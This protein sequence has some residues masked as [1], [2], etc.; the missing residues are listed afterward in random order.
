M[1]EGNRKRG[2][3]SEDAESSKR[4]L[5]E[6]ER[7][8]A[9]KIF[10]KSKVK[11]DLRRQ[12]RAVKLQ[13]ERVDALHR[14]Y[15]QVAN[16]LWFRGDYQEAVEDGQ[17][18][19]LKDEESVASFG[20]EQRAVE[21]QDAAL[22]FLYDD[23]F[24]IG[25]NE[26]ALDDMEDIMHDL[27]EIETRLDNGVYQD[28]Y[29]NDYTVGYNTWREDEDFITDENWSP[30]PLPEGLVGTGKARRAKRY[31]PCVRNAHEKSGIPLARLQESYDRG[32]GAWRTN[33]SSVRNRKGVKGG[34]GKRMPKEQWASARVNKLARLR[35]RAGYDKDLLGKG[36][37]CQ[38]RSV[39][40]TRV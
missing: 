14:M 38:V 11:D 23:E 2:R 16:D 9:Q 20:L 31:D 8:E 17:E 34:P 24:D 6:R 4:S 36:M 12:R 33:P 19:Y 18:Q 25:K 40:A 21:Q 13:K 7:D 29:G 32:I 35:R 5:T 30:P 26:L 37:R 10:F 22:R 28:E 15:D 27:E 39:T 3:E 1:S